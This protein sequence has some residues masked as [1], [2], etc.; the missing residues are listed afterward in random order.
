MTRRIEDSAPSS[1]VGCTRDRKGVTSVMN[2]EIIIR[3]I[4]A[5]SL[6][7][8]VITVGGAVR[9]CPVALVDITYSTCL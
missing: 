1:R 3:H 2:A 7:V 4:I 9:T 8:A 5:G 6:V